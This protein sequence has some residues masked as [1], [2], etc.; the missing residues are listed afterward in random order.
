MNCLNRHRFA[1]ILTRIA[2][3]VLAP[4]LLFAWR[5]VPGKAAGDPGPA[6]RS[7]I[8]S[9]AQ[10]RRAVTAEQSVVVALKVEGTVWWADARHG[11]LILHDTSGTDLLGLDLPCR[12]PRAGDRLKLEGD[13]AVVPTT[14]GIKLT[15]IPVVDNDGLHAAVEKSASIH[16]ETGFHPI[17][18]AWFNR[19]DKSE[20][21]LQYEGP[22]L[23]R[24]KVPDS[25]LFRPQAGG[26]TGATN[27]VNGL[28]YR[29]CESVG[30]SM[31][32]DLNHLA[33]VKSGSVSN[34]TLEVAS[35]GEHVGLQF[36]GCLRIARE[37]DY[38]FHLKSDDGSRLYIG[39]PT[40]RV[41]VPGTAPLPPPRPVT[42]G[43]APPEMEDYQWSEVEGTV[44]SVNRL[45]DGLEIELATAAGIMRLKV[46][47]DSNCSFT[48]VPQNRI[49]AVGACR[50][51]LRVDGVKVPG[52]CFVQGWNDIE[53]RYVTPDLWT[54]Y[55]LVTISNAASAPAFSNP[56]PVVHLRG[57]LRAAANGHP[58]ALEDG[59]GSITLNTAEISYSVGETV[60]VLGRLNRQGANLAL[61]C[62]LFRR[63]G[64]APG[65]S[66]SL[67]ILTTADQVNQLS[68]E[69]L[70]RGYPVRLRGVVTSALQ[71]DA[72]TVQ[73]ATRGI[74]VNM[75]R[76]SP[77]RAG[78]YCELEGHTVPGEFSPF[79][80]A[81]RIER[82]GPGILPPP[83][84]PSWDQLL[85]GSL[86]CQYVE[87]EGVVTS[88]NGGTITLLTRD[89]PINVQLDAMAPP[90]PADY[91]NALVRLRGC[92]FAAWDKEARRVQVGNIRLLQQWVSVIQPAPADLFA[93]PAKKAEDLLRFDP[94]AG[95]LQRVRVA[96]QIVHASRAGCFL[97]DGET[98]LRFIYAGAP[99]AQ[100]CDLVE[101]VGFPDL[102]GPSP[103][104][105][106]A[107]VRR[108]KPAGLPRPRP[109][110]PD[111][112]VRDEY[113]S[114]RVQMDGVLLGVNRKA[115]EAVLEMQSGWHLFTAAVNDLSGFDASLSPGCRLRLTGVYAGQGG[116]R[117]LSRP[118]D[119]FQLLLNSGFD[120][121][122]L[123]RPP[124]WTLMRLLTVVGLL[125]GILLAALV[126]IKLLQRQVAE[127][128][129]QLEAQIGERQHAEQQRAVEQERARM[130]QDLHDDLG[131][132]LT[133]VNMLGSLARS[134]ATTADEKSRYLDQLTGVARRLVTSLDE[135]VWAVNPRNDS[136]ASLA[137]YFASYA[138]QF[139]ELASVSCGLDIAEDLPRF[140]INSKFRHMVFL[141]FKEALS[142]IARHA[143]ASEARLQIRVE[144]QE[145]VLALT[146]N[147][148]GLGAREPGPGADGLLNMRER[149]KALGGRCDIR[150][151][152]KSGTTVQFRV[153]VPPGQP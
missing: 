22:G 43:P 52:Q 102:S 106:E 3:R 30:W 82:L 145:L 98:G 85:N 25:A 46:A 23:A 26:S 10:L 53:Q 35:R 127:R 45:Q 54:T 7:T 65:E 83:A 88:I 120:I 2:G 96:G 16:L 109:L 143:A 80:S 11:T 48:L 124:W 113:D 24:R 18:V 103:L 147:G 84:H 89:G 128:T 8:T 94:R 57:Q 90:L 136:V 33:A 86:H 51:L 97:M 117:V 15:S 135:I 6:A 101:V 130:A 36:S 27:L 75:G 39:E 76:P 142:N 108:L 149:I 34:F 69:E 140:P 92:L 59:S 63:L 78:D 32:P 148:R 79:I 71:G 38:T 77:L 107:V 12:M 28:D 42:G 44:T 5:P 41:T 20:L 137:S 112:L 133:E 116:N 55:P 91:R 119:S 118:I 81:S 139:L 58:P 104:L 9:L 68:A 72:V 131:A 66:G 122:V 150:S 70:N 121:Q 144:G 60:E 134:P 93:V 153:P 99:T 126:W 73:D 62:G 95:A 105:R 31:L 123:S 64:G 1:S 115:D 50:S 87:L 141:A 13:C 67:P 19:T 129:L 125:L 29:C 146:D 49:R 114:K 4:I 37:G 111:D 132:G 138:Q 74:F 110:D 47:E 152:G 100:V 14:D 151:E 56:P 17:R 21:E 61:E 40:V